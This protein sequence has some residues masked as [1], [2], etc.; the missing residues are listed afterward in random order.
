MNRVDP[1][2]LIADLLPAPRRSFSAKLRADQDRQ[3]WKFVAQALGLS[4]S[5]IRDIAGVPDEPMG[6][7][8][9]WEQLHPESTV[10]QLLEA[11]EGIPRRDLVRAIVSNLLPT[12][13]PSSPAPSSDPD[14]HGARRA[15]SQS[16]LWPGHGSPPSGGPLVPRSSMPAVG[17]ICTRDHEFKAMERF[18]ESSGAERVTASRPLGNARSIVASEWMLRSQR[19]VDRKMVVI[20]GPVVVAHFG[21]AMGVVTITLRVPIFLQHY[22]KINDLI[23][24]GICGG[25]RLGRVIVATQVIPLNIGRTVAKENADGHPVRETA[26]T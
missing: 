4:N 12:S 5:D 7:L 17:V 16:S 18:L 25:T 24:P 9:K 2:L 23:M 8:D 1:T 22:P 14:P 21:K 15:L 10:Q 3:S 11:L 13:T 19:L 26:A 20:E 6:I